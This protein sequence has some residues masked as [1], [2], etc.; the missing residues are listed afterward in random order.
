[1]QK[2]FP[3][4]VV[5]TIVLDFYVTDDN[6]LLQDLIIFLDKDKNFAGAQYNL[7]SQKPELKN[8]ISDRPRLL[9][10]LDIG[11]R[12]NQSVFSIDEW[13][14][15]WEDIYGSNIIISSDLL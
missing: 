1:M 12:F 9:R 10:M 8:V 5:L 2:S 11:R 3:L 13:L 4:K 6:F 15:Y 14:E 7:L